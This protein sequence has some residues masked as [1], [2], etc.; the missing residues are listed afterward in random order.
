MLPWSAQWSSESK[1]EKTPIS[2]LLT[3]MPTTLKQKKCKFCWKEFIPKSS[4]INCCT[5]DCHIAHLENKHKE[6]RQKLE[7][8]AKLRNDIF[9][10][11]KEKKVYQISKFSKKN[12]NQRRTFTQETIE[13]VLERDGHKCIICGSKNLESAPHHAFYGMEANY[14]DNRNDPDQVVTICIDCH[15]CIHSKGDR[16]KRSFC[17]DYLTNFYGKNS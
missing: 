16:Y 4:L 5:Y 15:Y 14:G 9:E 11:V 1:N 17:K 3:N 6:K 8:K 13:K 12:N 10:E 7:D 2:D